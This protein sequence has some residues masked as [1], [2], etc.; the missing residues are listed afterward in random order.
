VTVATF[1]PA[2]GKG[3]LGCGG[4][5]DSVNRSR[6]QDFVWAAAGSA[7]K[8]KGFLYR[9]TCHASET[10]HAVQDLLDQPEFPWDGWGLGGRDQRD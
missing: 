2:W 3:L 8:A 1:L 6:A 4:Q 7:E 9:L 5:S 10:P